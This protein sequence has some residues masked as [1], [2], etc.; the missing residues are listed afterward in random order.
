MPPVATVYVSVSVLVVVPARV[1]VGLIEAVP[2]PSALLL[3]LT[4]GEL[5]ID[6]RVPPLVDFSCTVH[7]AEPA[8]AADGAV[9]APLALVLVS[10]YRTRIV[11]PAFS[12]EAVVT[13]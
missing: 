12:A 11:S 3:T 10:P 5:L 4:L 7:V 13:V 6:V 1:E 8:F 2:D 9:A